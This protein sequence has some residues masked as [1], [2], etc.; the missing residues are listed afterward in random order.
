M[1][2][3]H[4]SHLAASV[5]LALVA[6]T[7]A[8]SA[9]ALRS[10]FDYR[11]VELN[12]DGTEALVE[13]KKVRPGETIEYSIVHSNS[14]EDALTGLVVQAPVPEGVTITFGSQSSSVDARFEIQAEMEPET[15]GLEWS[16]LPAFRKVIDEDGKERLEP[17]PAEAVTA[18]RW[19]LGAALPGGGDAVNTYR[20]VVN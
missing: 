19:S 12:E 9:D 4:A 20:V 17:L 2:F 14:T 3:P 1:P 7:Q 13:R 11:I 10:L 5:A 16:V 6:G 18:V 8:A 15:P